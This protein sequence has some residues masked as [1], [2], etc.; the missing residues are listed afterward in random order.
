MSKPT[1]VYMHT[2][3]FRPAYFNGEQLVHAYRGMPLDDLLVNSLKEIRQQQKKATEFRRS[4]GWDA[5]GY[6]YMLFKV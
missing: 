6:G 4:H 1:N 2:M 5:D 3:D